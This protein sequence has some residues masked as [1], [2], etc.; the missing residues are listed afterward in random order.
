MLILEMLLTNM[1]LILLHLGHIVTLF[2]EPGTHIKRLGNLFASD[3]SAF[4]LCYRHFIPCPETS[5]WKI[6]AGFG[7]GEEREIF[8]S[9][10]HFE[11]IGVD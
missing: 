5:A 3:L 11:S 9:Q 7:R 2:W 1:V 8:G 4:H 10:E 6:L